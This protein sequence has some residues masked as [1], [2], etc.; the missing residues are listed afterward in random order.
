LVDLVLLS[1]NDEVFVHVGEGLFSEVA[2]GI[3]SRIGRQHNLLGAKTA[4]FEAVSNATVAYAVIYY[5]TL[6]IL[7]YIDVHQIIVVARICNRIMIVHRI[8][9]NFWATNS[10]VL[11]LLRSI[12]RWDSTSFLGRRHSSL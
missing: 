3:R 9:L 11:C 10:S 5:N 1:R 7:I 4:W 2:V 12:S 6:A 8:T